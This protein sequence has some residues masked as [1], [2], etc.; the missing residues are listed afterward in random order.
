M[1][2]LNQERLVMKNICKSFPGVKALDNVSFDINAGEVHSLIGQNGAGK[3]SYFPRS[4][5]SHIF[6]RD[7]YKLSLL[8]RANIPPPLVPPDLSWRHDDK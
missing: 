8:L 2:T 7:C 6:Y 1:N 5:N 3:S 4:E